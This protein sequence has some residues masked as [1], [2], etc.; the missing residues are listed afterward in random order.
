MTSAK[1]A[2]RSARFD[3]FT[4]RACRQVRNEL[5]H[6]LVTAITTRNFEP[7]STLV[8]THLSGNITTSI[9][10]Y[11]IDRR[12]RYHAIFMYIR[13]NGFSNEDIWPIALA[14]W[15]E[16][17]FFEVHEWLEHAWLQSQGAKREGY[18]AVIRAAGAYLHLEAGRRTSAA[19]LAAKAV[20]GL[21]RHRNLLADYFDVTRL[22]DKL[23]ALDP[24][25]PKLVPAPRAGNRTGA[26]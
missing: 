20:N 10:R 4:S 22:L 23:E 26:G 16:R 12:E 25:P 11:L 1:N 19:R 6:S 21:S 7:V 13:T 18:Q 24:V 14:L 9:Q 8:H 17:L 2:N 3:P 15:D 5:A